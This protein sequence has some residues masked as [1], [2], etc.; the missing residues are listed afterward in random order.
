VAD[1]VSRPLVKAAIGKTADVT[2]FMVWPRKLIGF[3]R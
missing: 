1:A 2:A 3:C